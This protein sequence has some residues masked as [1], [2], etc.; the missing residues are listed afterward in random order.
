MPS[1]YW[2]E[3]S[4]S[5]DLAPGEEVLLSLPVNHLS[6]RWHFEIPFTFKVPAGQVYR[7]EEVG[8]KPETRLRYDLADLPDKIQEKIKEF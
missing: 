3:L 6:T 1:G 4:S 7:P 5:L 8:G 2:G